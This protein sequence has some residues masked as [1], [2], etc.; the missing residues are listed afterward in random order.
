MKKSYY[1]LAKLHHP[2]KASE[3][4]KS[5]ANEKFSII[6]QSYTVLSNIEKRAQY[7]AGSN[8][9][10]ANA[11]VFAQWEYFIKPINDND[12]DNARKKYQNSEKE[13]LDILQEY[14]RGNGSMIHILN[15][16]PFM[17]IEDEQRIKGII[18]AMM[19]NGIIKEKIKIK[20]IHK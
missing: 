7:D 2:D 11:T 6:H 13:R 12:I 19:N 3:D 10:F 20:K 15:N 1:K 9:V 17:R 18:T 5:T 14:K 16:I 4:E 8:V